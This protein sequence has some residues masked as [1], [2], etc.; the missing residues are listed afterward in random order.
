MKLLI[1][2]MLAGAAW[3]Q[4]ATHSRIVVK[5]SDNPKIEC[6]LSPFEGDYKSPEG[7]Q[8]CSVV[9]QTRDAQI[10]SQAALIKWQE[11]EIATMKN[12]I[13]ALAQFWQLEVQSIQHQASK[14]VVEP[15]KAKQ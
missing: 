12:K 11:E 7:I 6:A 2:L 10:A 15:A 3:G 1:V 9:I 5:L 8:L 4:E 13:Q 14:P